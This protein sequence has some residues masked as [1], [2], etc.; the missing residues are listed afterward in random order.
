M[1][2]ISRTCIVV[3]TFLLLLLLCVQAPLI[4]A[5]STWNIQTVDST[6]DVGWYTSLALD[7]SGNPHISYDDQTNGN[8]KYAAWTGSA[9]NIQTVDSGENAVYGYVGFYTSLALDSSGNPHISYYDE[10]NED[11]KYAAWTSS[12]WNIQTV[13]STGDVGWF[14]SLALDSSG[15]PH[16]S[17]D[18]LSNGNLKYAAWTGSAWNIQTVDS[19]KSNLDT[20]LALDSSGNPHISYLDTTNAYLKYATWTGSTWNIQTIGL[21][22]EYNSLALDSSGNPHISYRNTTIYGSLNYAAWTGSAWNI[23][24][25]DSSSENVGE[26]TSIALDSSGNPHISYY[27]QINGDLKYAVFVSSQTST[28]TPTSTSPTPTPTVPEFPSIII[29]SLLTMA[30]LVAAVFFREK[31]KQNPTLKK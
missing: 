3:F 22:G 2:H 14:T 31:E 25:V 12:A 13:D 15:N 29:M 28:P 8:L 1:K 24:T 6:G 23:Q 10:I 26:F 30:T 20:S 17:Y 19:A 4:K 9:W 18:D 16:I 11:L 27:D 21:G 5:I 7:S